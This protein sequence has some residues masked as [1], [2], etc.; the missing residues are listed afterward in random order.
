M[1]ASLAAAFMLSSS[2]GAF[3]VSDIRVEGIQRTEP[4]TVFAHLPFSAGDEYSPA[5]ATRSIHALYRS[6]L[7]KD[8]SLERDGNVVVVRVV[9]RPAVSDIETS[10]IKAFDKNAIEKSLRDVG[11]GEGRIFDRA[12]LDRA[13]QEL[14]RQYLARGFY[15]VKI[16]TTVTPLERNRVRVNIAVDEG[17]PAKIEGIRFV[18]NTVFSTGDLMDEMQL[19]PSNMWSW[20]TK[21]DL[22]SREKLAADLESLRSFYLNR[23]YLDFRVDSVQ[24]QISPN[25]DDVYLTVNI[26]EGAPYKI[27]G[28]KLNGDMLGLDDIFEKMVDVKAGQTFNAERV[29]EVSRRMTAKLSTLGYAFSKADPIPVM[30]KDAHTVELVYTVDPGRRVYVRRVNVTG[31]NRTRD[32]VIRREVTQYEDSWYDS[33][34]VAASRDRVDRLG[35]FEE[36]AAD[37]VPVP[38][39]NNQVDLEV[40]VKE[41]PTGQLSLGAGYSSSDGVVLTGGFAQNNLRGTGKALSVN[42]NTSKSQRT[43]AVSVDEPYITTTGISRS[44]DLSLQT[45]D[46]SKEKSNSNKKDVKYETRKAGINFGIPFTEYDRVYL[47][48][49]VEQLRTINAGTD[50]QYLAFVEK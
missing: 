38:G 22:Y 43:Y 4:G 24:V 32:D 35:F 30:D 1:A 50:V 34:K 46:R 26:H 6:G 21:R 17:R 29:N 25:R 18:G 19:H 42:I 20:Y 49:R 9:E 12:V 40:R 27:S 16:N 23:G 36:V 7:F 41:R 3:V 11:L 5:M 8:V 48:G 31:N 14:R 13:D 33:A 15:A 37:P 47:G 39:T 2:A 44:W 28:V 10:G 45:V